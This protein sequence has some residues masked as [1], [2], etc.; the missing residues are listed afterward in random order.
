MQLHAQ[1]ATGQEV[2]DQRPLDEKPGRVGLELLQANRGFE[3]AQA[4]LQARVIPVVQIGIA[5]GGGARAA[6]V[7]LQAKGEIAVDRPLKNGPQAAQHEAIVAADA[8]VIK[9]GARVQLQDA[10]QTQRKVIVG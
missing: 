1:V 4:K 9:V 10:M 5:N 2:R 6:E 3:F 7:R 8:A